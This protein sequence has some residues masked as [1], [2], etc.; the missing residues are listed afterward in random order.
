MNNNL[1]RSFIRDET[2]LLKSKISTQIMLNLDQ[3]TEE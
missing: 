1:N 3:F 2:P